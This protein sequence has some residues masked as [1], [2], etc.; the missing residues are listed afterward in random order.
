MPVGF[1][2]GGPAKAGEVESSTIPDIARHLAVAFAADRTYDLILCIAHPPRGQH[3]VNVKQNPIGGIKAS[4]VSRNA[5]IAKPGLL[6]LYHQLYNGFNDEDLLAEI[7]ELYD[8][9]VISGR[10]LDI[11]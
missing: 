8:G 4:Q 2:S 10:D 9:E 3:W 6:I 11:Y 7:R 1:S 5:S